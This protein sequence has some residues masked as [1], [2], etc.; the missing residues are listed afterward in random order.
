MPNARPNIIYFDIRGRA[1][2][3]RLMFEELGVAYDEQRLRSSAQWRA[4]KPQTPFG[5]LPIYEEGDLR[6]AQTQAIYR[7]I[8]RTRDLY[9]RDERERVECDVGAEAVNEAIETLWRFFWEPDYKDKLEAFAGGPLAETLLDL[10]RWF[11]RSS[12]APT[13]WVGN[14]LTYVDFVAYRY[15]DEVDALFPASLAARPALLAFHRAFQA[16]PGIAAYL[17]SG[18]RPA[19][20]GICID[21]LKLDPRL[22]RD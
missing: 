10:E 22:A 19:V 7:H 11:T 9:G 6:F 3:I 15:L 2:A 16:R 5:A 14:A 17:A 4:M 8:A 1:E 21:G 13:Y 18:R 20:F 12:R